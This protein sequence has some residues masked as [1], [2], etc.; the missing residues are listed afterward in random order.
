MGAHGD[1]AREDRT[2]PLPESQRLA[3]AFE[4][5]GLALGRGDPAIVDASERHHLT[6]PRRT[7]LAL[8]ADRGG[9]RVGEIARA[10]GMSDAT[11][12]RTVDALA[13]SGLVERQPDP[14]DR[15]SVRVVATSAGRQLIDRRRRTFLAV[16]ARGLERLSPPERDR[17]V[18][19]VEAL[20]A[21]LD[22][23]G[24]SPAHDRAGDGEHVPAAT[25]VG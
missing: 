20:A 4:R 24:S 11:A 3:A 6:H 13:R 5:I 10:T 8:L 19:L 21:E 2:R 22:R 16:L 17:L 14:H 18:E 25:R 9:M 23:L 12:S 15:R 7:V 1:S